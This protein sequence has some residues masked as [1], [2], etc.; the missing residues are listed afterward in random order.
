[1]ISARKSETW[2][3]HALGVTPGGFALIQQPIDRETTLQKTFPNTETAKKK[4]VK[5]L[6]TLE[7]NLEAGLAPT[8]PPPHTGRLSSPK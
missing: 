5:P 2:C 3:G 1:M 4:P 8:H 7:K 6:E